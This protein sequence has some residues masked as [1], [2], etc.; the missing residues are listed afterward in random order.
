MGRDKTI[1]VNTRIIAA[2]NQNL[3]DLIEKGEFREDLYYRLN[4]INLHASPLRDR[5]GD[6][7]LL[8]MHFLKKYSKKIFELLRVLPRKQWRNWSIITGPEMSGN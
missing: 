6:I 1:K 3:I 7:Q 4:V 8:A 2:T 5:I